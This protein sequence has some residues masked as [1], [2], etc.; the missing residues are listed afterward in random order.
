MKDE[1]YEQ[2]NQSEDEV[3]Q[4][5]T[6]LQKQEETAEMSEA[7]ATEA[8][9]DAKEV[10]AESGEGSETKTGTEKKKKEMTL[11]KKWGMVVAMALVFGLIAGG[12]M[13]GVNA[14]ANRLYSQN[15]ISQTDTTEASTSESSS[16]VTQVADNAMPSVVTISTMS[17]EEMRSFFGGTQQ[18]E[19][20]GAGT[21]VIIG[22]NDTEL[23]IATNNHV[24]EGASSLSVGFIDESTVSAEIKGTDAENDLAVISVKLSDISKDTMNQIKIASIGDSDELQLGEQV[25]AIGNALGYGQSV[26]SGYVSALNRDLSLTDES[27]NTINSTGLIQTDAAIN[28]GNSGGALLN[29]NGELIGINEAKS[30]TTSS[31]TTVDNI[32]FAIPINKAQESLQNLMNQET[33]EKVSEDQ[34]S[35]IGI[36][37]A[38]VSSDEQEK[39]SIPA[40]VVVASV[41]EDGPAAQAGIQEGDIITELDGRSV[42]SIEGLQDTLQYYAAG[43]TVDIV[44]QRADNGSYQEQTLSITLGSAQDAETNN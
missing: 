36:Q 34:A 3:I 21:G 26:T 14:A 42:S 27:G 32:G 16:G 38:S 23:L 39:F 44:V 31:G 19:V 7:E 43:E 35:Y 4:E 41:V 30:G 40:G 28:P 33:R 15:H 29:M 13:Y 5:Q 37:G 6:D 17:V 18:Y 12:T 2:E 11:Q 1:M 9:T 25:V 20:E 8:E 22:E 10:K 24:V